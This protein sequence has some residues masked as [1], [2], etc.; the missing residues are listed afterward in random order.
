MNVGGKEGGGVGHDWTTVTAA[1]PSAGSDWFPPPRTGLTV[2]VRIMKPSK[3]TL[4]EKNC[5]YHFMN[6]MI[7]S[8]VRNA[9][10]PQ[11]AADWLK[12]PVRHDLSIYFRTF[13]C[14]TKLM[15]A[16]TPAETG[17]QH[18]SYYA[19]PAAFDRC[20]VGKERRKK[21]Q[22]PAHIKRF[23]I[24]QDNPIDLQTNLARR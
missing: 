17:A 14:I 4:P 3:P 15:G 13:V 9:P 20:E 2:S 11:R 21:L 8:L 1:P 5:P 22:P 23:L 16:Q 19:R 12:L 18:R 10:A 7:R 6:E 24:S